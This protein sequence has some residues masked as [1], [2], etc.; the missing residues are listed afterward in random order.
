MN[1][2][3]EHRA[4][5][6]PMYPRLPDTRNPQPIA[7]AGFIV[8]AQGRK[9]HTNVSDPRHF[10]PTGKR[11]SMPHVSRDG[12][13]VPPP[14][15]LPLGTDPSHWSS[16]LGGFES[17][18]SFAPSG[19]PLQNEATQAISNQ[20]SQAA[21]GKGRELDGNQQPMRE[22]RSSPSG[23][24]S[25]TGNPEQKD[26]V[27]T[28]QPIPQGCS[29]PSGEFPQTGS[30]ELWGIP[31][32]TQRGRPSPLSPAAP[33]SL[34]RPND[35]E[36]ENRLDKVRKLQA[37]LDEMEKDQLERAAR[38]A[39][40]EEEHARMLAERNRKVRI[41]IYGTTWE[42]RLTQSIDEAT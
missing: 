39:E 21:K 37:Q 2:D 6:A 1:L 4:P 8:E 16:T 13:E 35:D 33:G 24:P 28:Q 11:R 27:D 23:L 42:P 3:Q 25:Q 9:P 19:T 5:P 20:G 14:H 17:D 32:S 41:D 26:M 18:R 12:P 31:Q 40:E 10:D 15:G 22:G 36:L 34:K 7:S 29:L 38:L 30:Q